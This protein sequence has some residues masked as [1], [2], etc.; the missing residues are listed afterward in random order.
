MGHFVNGSAAA[1]VTEPVKPV[2]TALANTMP[3]P[4]SAHALQVVASCRAF[5]R[6]GERRQGE[7]AH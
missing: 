5:L 6:D 3:R 1:P 2:D 4:S 7:H